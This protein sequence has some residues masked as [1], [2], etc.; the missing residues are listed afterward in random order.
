MENRPADGHSWPSLVVLV[1]V[2]DTMNCSRIAANEYQPLRP[3]RR[4]S[5]VMGGRCS[6]RMRGAIDPVRLMR[7]SLNEYTLAIV[8]IL[9]TPAVDSNARSETGGTT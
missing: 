3:A 2:F 6:R 1:D 7:F 9:G 4:L 5:T 8:A